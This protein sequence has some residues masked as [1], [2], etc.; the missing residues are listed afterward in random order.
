MA[1]FCRDDQRGP[2]AGGKAVRHVRA[3]KLAAFAQ[4]EHV[5]KQAQR[6]AAADC[7]ALHGRDHGKLAVQREAKGFVV[8]EAGFAFLDR[9]QRLFG[10]ARGKI[11]VVPGQH[12]HFIRR[13]GCDLGK[14]FGHSGDELVGEH[15]FCIPV[16]HRNDNDAVR[17]G[18]GRDDG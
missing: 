10:A 17:M 15:V 6:Q 9:H 2:G 13:R 14:H 1:H 8:G 3:E 7:V 4:D 12:H 16:C 18:R 5:G 11:A